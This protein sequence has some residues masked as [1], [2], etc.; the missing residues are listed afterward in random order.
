[1]KIP[2]GDVFLNLHFMTRLVVR[3]QQIKSEIDAVLLQDGDRDVC[4][5]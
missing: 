3:K 5:L 1:M 2:N 4:C